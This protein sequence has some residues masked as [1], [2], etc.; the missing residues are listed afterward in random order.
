MPIPLVLAGS[1]MW[2]RILLC[3]VVGTTCVAVT[4]NL[5]AA[6]DAVGEPAPSRE[7]PPPGDHATHHPR[8][9]RMLTLGA[10]AG[11]DNHRRDAEYESKACH[12]DRAEAKVGRFDGGL[13][14][15]DGILLR[16]SGKKFG[17]HGFD[18]ARSWLIALEARQ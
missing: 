6:Q 2:C 4:C 11:R 16:D 12:Q 5:A 17:P 13:V 7:A 3:L 10:R 18:E 14:G 1:D 8:A 15:L 9:K